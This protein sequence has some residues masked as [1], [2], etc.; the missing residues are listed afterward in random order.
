MTFDVKMKKQQSDMHVLVVVHV[1]VQLGENWND[2]K[3]SKY[4]FWFP[5]FSVRWYIAER[6]HVDGG[7]YN[8]C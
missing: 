6:E 4:T 8:N 2:I 1:L 7:L 5:T 3:K